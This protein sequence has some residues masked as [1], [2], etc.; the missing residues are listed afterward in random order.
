MDAFVKRCEHCKEPVPETKRGRPQKFCSDRCRQAHR[1]IN[2][3]AEGGLRYRTGRLKPKVASQD[4]EVSRQSE[5]ENLSQKTNLRFERVNEVTFKLTDGEAH[6]RTRLAWSVGWLP[7]HEGSGLGHQYRA[8]PVVGAMSRRDLRTLILQR[9]KGECSRNGEGRSWRLF[10]RESN[11]PSQWTAG[12]PDRQQW[13]AAVMARRFA[14]KNLDVVGTSHDQER[15]E[16]KG[17]A[18]E[19]ALDPHLSVVCPYPAQPD[20]QPKQRGRYRSGGTRSI[21]VAQA[22]NLIEAVNFAKSIGLPLVAH[23]T[24]HWSGTVAFDDHD[25]TRFAKVR[26]GLK[27]VLLRRGIP[28]AWA[29]CREC[30]AHT[31]IVHCHLLF[32]LARRVSRGSFRLRLRCS[33]LLD[34]TVA[35]FWVSSRSS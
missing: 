11:R 20:R 5:P 18:G 8:W 17:P 30:K 12:S 33:D 24:L 26:E 6:Q 15:L 16:P 14:P 21:S 13:G 35:G 9:G 2:A 29:W 23:L 32:P 22:T 34:D 1:K 7:H 28:P 10:H 4:S 27:K 3:T 19:S 31:D 25:G